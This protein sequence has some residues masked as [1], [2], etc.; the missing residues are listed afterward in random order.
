[1][2]GAPIILLALLIQTAAEAAGDFAGANALRGLSVFGTFGM[3]LAFTLAG[4]LT[5][6]I[7]ATLYLLPQIPVAVWLFSRL[8]RS[9]R[10]TLAGFPEAAWRLIAY[11]LRCYPSDLLNTAITYV[12]QVVVVTLLAP[13]A[14]GLFTVSI[15][16]AR[17]L[18]I[19]YTTVSTVL[20]PATAAGSASDVVEKTLR[21]SRLTL[22]LMTMFALPL[23]LIIPVILPIVYGASFSG[24]V[25]I[26]RVLLIEGIISGAVWVLM[27][28]FLALDRPEL[29]TILQALVLAVSG[30][31][32]LTLVP[33]YG[34]LGAAVVLLV[35]SLV[36]LCLV[37]G[38][39][40]SVL[41]VPLGR[42]FFDRGDISY[43][44]QRVLS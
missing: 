42:L 1:M 10:P 12:G 14:V 24:A 16:I 28:A 33:K 19:F 7:A 8:H 25:T 37:A 34:G 20:L 43:L 21:A 39:Y 32:L 27:Q 6:V 11:G 18:E 38:L 13:T 15:G 41:S 3:V 26:A 23:L 31:L 22:L 40:R 5:P 4:A 35:V 30:S 36:K 29:G 2:L 44:K 9:Y 17:M